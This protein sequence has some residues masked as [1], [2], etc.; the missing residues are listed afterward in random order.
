MPSTSCP[1]CGR[2]IQ[3]QLHELNAVLECAV[4]DQRFTPAS[5][6]VDSKTVHREPDGDDSGAPP[7][8]PRERTS[9]RRDAAS[10]PHSSSYPPEPWFYRSITGYVSA[11][12]WTC[13]LAVVGTVLLFGFVA[14]K[15]AIDVNPIGLVL[16]PVFVMGAIAVILTIRFIAALFLIVVDAARKLRSID[17]KM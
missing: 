6:P 2:K 13:I 1:G 16:L 11:W 14:I 17:H 4:C 5:G 3:F 8:P 10:A 12:M 15:V 9:F 7:P